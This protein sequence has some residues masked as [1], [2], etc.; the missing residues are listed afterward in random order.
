MDDEETKMLMEEYDPEQVGYVKFHDV[1]RD[2]QELTEDLRAKGIYS[3]I[4]SLPQVLQ[5]IKRYLDMKGLT[6][7]ELFNKTKLQADDQIN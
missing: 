4:V 2:Y 5:S 1:E 7:R 3:Q 6:L